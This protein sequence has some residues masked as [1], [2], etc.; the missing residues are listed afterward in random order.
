M[1]IGIIL[2]ARTSSTRLPQKVL[3]ELPLGS[4]VT[5]L[6]HIIKRLK[7]SHMTDEVIVATTEEKSDDEIVKI[8]K[9]ENVKYYRGSV[10]DVLE[11]YYGAAKENAL[12]IIVR[13]TGDCPC[14][15]PE[16]IDLVIN[17]HLEKKGDYTAN[18]VKR[19]YP[20]GLDVEV[21]N[22]SI[23]EKMYKEADQP[24]EREHVT[25]YI[26][27]HKEKFKIFNVEAGQELYAPDRRITLDTVQDYTLLCA[28]FDALYYENK[29]FNAHAIMK[30]FDERPWLDG[31]NTTNA[32]AT[33]LL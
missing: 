7:K 21:F 15:D 19:S 1:K 32:E 11:R 12:D 23:L 2:Q 14:I 9:N 30:F 26:H 22:S 13:I 4:G 24:D 18:I 10:M 3:K 33:K 27:K 20:D 25:V 29:Y 5:V 8:A 16:I 31:I 28:L 17:K 6:Q